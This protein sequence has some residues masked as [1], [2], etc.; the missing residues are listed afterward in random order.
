MFSKITFSSFVFVCM[1]ALL[2]RSAKLLPLEQLISFRKQGAQAKMQGDPGGKFII[3]C[4][5]CNRQCQKKA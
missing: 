4:G 3:L 1:Y 2:L 5:D